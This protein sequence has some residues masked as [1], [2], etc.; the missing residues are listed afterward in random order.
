MRCYSWVLVLC[1]WLFP[2]PFVIL[3]LFILGVLE[4]YTYVCSYNL[5]LLFYLD[6]LEL[7]GLFSWE[8]VFLPVWEMFF[9]YLFGIISFF[10]FFLCSPILECS[11]ANVGF[12]DWCL[13]S[14]YLFSCV[15]CLCF[16]CILIDS[17]S[18]YILPC[19]VCTFLPKFVREK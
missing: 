18:Y 2:S 3:N 1:K 14:F 17:F 12:L 5:F 8:C 11:P 15:F 10:L 9:Y 16:F 13:M 7:V 4:F 6:S 19:I